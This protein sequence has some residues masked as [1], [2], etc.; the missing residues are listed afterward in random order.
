[1]KLLIFNHFVLKKWQFHMFQPVMLIH[2][3]FTIDFQ[4]CQYHPHFADE[5]TKIRILS[6]LPK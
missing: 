1:M 2:L 3:I 6:N 5:E 4:A